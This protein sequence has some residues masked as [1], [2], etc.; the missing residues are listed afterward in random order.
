M[1][2]RRRPFAALQ[3]LCVA[4]GHRLLASPQSLC[5]WSHAQRRVRICAFALVQQLNCVPRGV[6]VMRIRCLEV[7]TDAS[8]PQ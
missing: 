2:K 4:K 3:S 7:V 8:D 5:A 6:A 1:E